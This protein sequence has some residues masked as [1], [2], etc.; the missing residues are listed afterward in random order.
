MA[1]KYKLKEQESSGEDN[2]KDKATY[3]LVLTPRSLSIIEVIK[4]LENIDNYGPYVSNL[5]NAAADVNKEVEAHFGPSQPWAKKAKEK[6]RGKPFPPKT[7]QAVDDFIK[8]LK[9]KPNLLKWTIKGEELYF[10]PSKN[11]PKQVTK[12]IIDTVMK[13]ANIDY[14]I[15]EKEAMNEDSLREMIKEILYKKINPEKCKKVF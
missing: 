7:K 2:A 6:E 3:D 14:S 9:S 10:S 11:P 1:Y 12:N 5:R 4:A 8:S 13:K 15:E